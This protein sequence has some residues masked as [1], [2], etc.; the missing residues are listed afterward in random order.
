[1][2]QSRIHWFTDRERNGPLEQVLSFT[3]ENTVDLHSMGKVNPRTGHE[4][5]EGKYR[6][7]STLSLTSA[8][9]GG[10]VVNA[11]PQPFYPRERDPIPI[12]QE[13]GCTPGPVWTGAEYL[14]SLAFDPRTVQPV[15]S[16]YSLL[17]Y[18]GTRKTSVTG[19]KQ[20]PQSDQ[21]SSQQSCQYQEQVCV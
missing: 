4:G 1:M 7:I 15:V 14:T 11:T 16:C 2:H 18:P 19:H 13:A 6:H 12:V 10:W 9:D 20:G 5:P 3:E 21:L 8:L 17:S